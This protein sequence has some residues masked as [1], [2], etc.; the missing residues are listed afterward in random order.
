MTPDLFLIN[1][2]TIFLILPHKPITRTISFT[3]LHFLVQILNFFFLDNKQT[4]KQTK[5][6]ESFIFLREKFG[7]FIL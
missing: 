3:T 5:K 7:P 4:N 6:G 2:T 1:T